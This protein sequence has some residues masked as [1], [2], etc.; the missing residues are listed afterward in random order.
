MRAAPSPRAYGR[1]CQRDGRYPWTRPRDKRGP[2]RSPSTTPVPWW[3]WTS[4]IRACGRVLVARQSR[5]APSE[6]TTRGG[7][8]KR[9]PADSRAR[10]GHEPRAVSGSSE[11]VGMIVRSLLFFC[12]AWI[13]TDENLPNTRAPKGA[14]VVKRS[15]RPFHH[16]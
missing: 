5:S 10:A 7:S 15:A 11:E 9:C 13:S 14:H 2:W 16:G 1:E 12:L 6:E 3:G 4:S 8:L